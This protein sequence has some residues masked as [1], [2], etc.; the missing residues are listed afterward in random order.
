MRK[1]GRITEMYT[2]GKFMT[3]LAGVFVRISSFQGLPGLRSHYE[4]TYLAIQ[5]CLLAL[6]LNVLKLGFIAIAMYNL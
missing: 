3:I 6:M 1:A 4:I 5:K 2:Q